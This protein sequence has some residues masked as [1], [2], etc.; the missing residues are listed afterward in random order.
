MAKQ[1]P[2]NED[3]YLEFSRKAM[4]ND[5]EKEILRTR[6]MGYTVVQ[7]SLMFHIS[8]STVHRIIKDLKHRYDLVQPGS[9]LPKR[10]SSAKELYMDEN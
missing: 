4:L 5:L 7:Q 8:E 6:I 3:I 1:V 9:G 10:K 2:W